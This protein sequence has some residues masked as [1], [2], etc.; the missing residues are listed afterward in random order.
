MDK[1]SRYIIIVEDSE[2][3]FESLI[4]GFKKAGI[5]NPVRRFVSG[6]DML[7]FL[8]EADERTAD[9]E[10]PLMIFLDLNIPDTSGWQVLKDIKSQQDLRG[11]P[12]VVTSSNEDP[13]EVALCYQ[14]GAN[15]YLLKMTDLATFHQHIQQLKT[16]WWE[17]VLLPVY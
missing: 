17:T 14:H 15:S 4:R 10:R 1:S 12:I 8:G 13:R 5:D 9:F 11:I 2:A 6:D 7:A 16:Y 3:D